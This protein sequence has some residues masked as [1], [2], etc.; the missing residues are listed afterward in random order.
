MKYFVGII[1]SAFSQYYR[2]LCCFYLCR[3]SRNVLARMRLVICMSISHKHRFSI[4]LFVGRKLIY[5]FPPS[6]RWYLKFECHLVEVIGWILVAIFAANSQPIWI[7]METQ[8]TPTKKKDEKN[9][10]FFCSANRNIC[11][12]YDFFAYFACTK[13]VKAIKDIIRDL[14]ASHVQWNKKRSPTQ[15]KLWPYEY[16]EQKKIRGVE[17]KSKYVT[18]QT[19]NVYKR[20]ENGM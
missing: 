12:Y 7:E 9:K 16:C 15:M 2:H 4:L 10:L 8:K 5:T 1:S 18:K 20:M 19:E 11:E 13:C 3:H 6:Y 14:N 17:N